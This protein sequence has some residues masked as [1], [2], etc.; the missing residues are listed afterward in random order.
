MLPFRA[1]AVRPA[2]YLDAVR[3]GRPAAVVL[4]ASC[5]GEYGPATHRVLS[6]GAEMVDELEARARVCGR[7]AADLISVS[8]H[9]VPRLGD[10]VA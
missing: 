5:H 1:P 3:Q 7:A 2:P 8:W 9:P 6:D 10:R 4:V